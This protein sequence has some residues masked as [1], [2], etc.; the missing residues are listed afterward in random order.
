M[1]ILIDKKITNTK[2]MINKAMTNLIHEAI[3]LEDEAIFAIL[4]SLK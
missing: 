2:L 4:S 1:I 3:L